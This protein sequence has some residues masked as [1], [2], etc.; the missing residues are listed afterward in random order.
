MSSTILF[1]RELRFDGVTVVS[2]SEV[3]QYLLLGLNPKDLRV[4]ELNLDIENFNLNVIQEERLNLNVD[5]VTITNEWLLD[6]KYLDLD[7]DQYVIQKFEEKLSTLSY[8]DVE[9]GAAISRISLE[10]EEFKKNGMLNLIR[11]II[12]VLDTFKARDQ[13]FGV[14]RG[15]SC[16]SYVLFLLGLHLVDPIKYDIPLTEFL[17]D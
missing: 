10:L 7:V 8:S 17:H 15:S 13:I 12:F 11:A 4:T 3:T 5:E 9:L 2:P 14:G 6:Q 1:D 16:A